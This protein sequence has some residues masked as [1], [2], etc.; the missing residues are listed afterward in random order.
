[1]ENVKDKTIREW[2]EAQQRLDPTFQPDVEDHPAGVNI[3]GH[4]YTLGELRTATNKLKAKQTFKPTAEPLAERE[5]LVNA[6]KAGNMGDLT[7]GEVLYKRV[8]KGMSTEP[9]EAWLRTQGL[10]L[11][12]G[13]TRSKFVKSFEAWVVNAGLQPGEAYTHPSFTNDA[14]QEIPM[15]LEGVSIYALYAARNLLTSSDPVEILAECYTS[16]QQ[17]LI[18]KASDRDKAFE[19]SEGMRS[20][21]K[22]PESMMELFKGLEA[23]FPGKS[24]IEVVQF[25]IQF[26]SDLA[27]RDPST[28]SDTV[29]AYFGEAEE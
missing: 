7:I 16:T 3:D 13:A 23:H 10:K 25:L 12:E 8:S 19:P 14:G 6:I 27:E 9:L 17:E 15:S 18:D 26:T 5:K 28:F 20:L 1:L 11:P 24:R 29:A 2:V 4:T 21:P 22:I